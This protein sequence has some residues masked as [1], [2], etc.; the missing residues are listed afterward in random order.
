MAL[1]VIAGILLKVAGPA[2]AAKLAG[3]VAKP[4]ADRIADQVVAELVDKI[5]CDPVLKNELNAEDPIQSRI[6]WGAVIAALGVLV[7][8][9]ANLL[10]LSITEDRV[11]E[12]GGAVVTLWGAGYVLYG[13]FKAG[14]KPLFSRR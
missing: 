4:D 11:V 8:I 13:R 12:I 10:G 3:K 2:I 9:G 5:G 1:P 6:A 14:L 7:P